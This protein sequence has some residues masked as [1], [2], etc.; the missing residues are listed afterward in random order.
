MIEFYYESR[1]LQYENVNE[2]FYDFFNDFTNFFFVFLK[3]ISS[4]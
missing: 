3:G 2:V 4:Y 1:L